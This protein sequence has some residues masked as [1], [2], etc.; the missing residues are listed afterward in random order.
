MPI[1]I[2][3][4]TQSHQLFLPPSAPF[5]AP[6]APGEASGPL[7]VSPGRRRRASRPERTLERRSLC[8]RETGFS[9]TDAELRE[10]GA[11]FWCA[12]EQRVGTISFLHAWLSLSVGTTGLEADCR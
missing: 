4:N 1:A 12:A 3:G 11:G 5:P 2:T 6:A 10:A 9:P 8:L 7:R